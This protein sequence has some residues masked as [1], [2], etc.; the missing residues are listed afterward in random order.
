MELAA[1]ELVKQNHQ[2]HAQL[3]GLDQVPKKYQALIK[4]T[5]AFTE[6]VKQIAR[7]PET[8]DLATRLL[9]DFAIYLLYTTE[10]SFHLML[11]SQRA[12][13]FWI[14]DDAHLSIC[15]EEWEKLE[16]GTCWPHSIKPVM[17][18]LG[19]ELFDEP[20]WIGDRFWD[21]YK[22]EIEYLNERKRRADPADIPFPYDISVLRETDVSYTR[23]TQSSSSQFWYF[24]QSRAFLQESRDVYDVRV[25]VN[26]GLQGKLPREVAEIIIEDVVADE[27][28]VVGTL[29]AK[30]LPKSLKR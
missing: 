5:E 28:G 11:N 12:H 30:Y 27:V 26:E 14:L 29:R 16:E 21:A 4:H 13:I 7:L 9:V 18:R 25:K 23:S 2:V 20:N 6:S 19:I 22:R 3:T 15:L 8:F 1:W 10:S 17:E 24:K